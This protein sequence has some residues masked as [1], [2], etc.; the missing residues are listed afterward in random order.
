MN[1][2]FQDFLPISVIL[3]WSK[4]QY[5]LANSLRKS[6]ENNLKAVAGRRGSLGSA[7]IV[8]LSGLIRS[9]CQH[10][11]LSY[12]LLTHIILIVSFRMVF[13]VPS[14]RYLYLEA[15]DRTT[16]Y[17]IPDSKWREDNSKDI[18]HYIH[19]VIIILV[20]MPKQLLH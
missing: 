9:L 19:L 18:L 14:I 6:L 4:W 10:R 11:T 2:R 20:T 16:F 5:L 13:E 1:S 15:R 8:V 3:K 7:G 17:S 12:G